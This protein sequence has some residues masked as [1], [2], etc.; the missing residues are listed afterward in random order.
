MSEASAVSEADARAMVRLLG[1]VAS[2]GREHSRMKR[3][4]MEGLSGLINADAWV[5]TLGCQTVLEKGQVLAGFM[6][7][8][9][10]E[11]R[12]ASFVAAV[13]NPQLAQVTATFYG[14]LLRD[15][16]QTTML[17]QEIDPDGL[18]YGGGMKEEWEEI[19]I[20][21]ILI[22]AYP[23]DQQ[24]YSAVAFYR[25]LKAPLFCDRDKQLLHIMM[26]EVPWLHMTGWPEDRG[27]QVP[28]LYPQQ[29]II[30][31]LLLDGSSRKEITRHMKLSEHT[32]SGY[33][34]DVFRHFGVN[35]QAS[36]M[37]K[38]MTK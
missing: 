20:G 1:D 13:E 16:K 10:D 29:R 9:F 7:G 2:H 15:Q 31:N 5:W 24:S 11:A 6:H 22:S 28:T 21:P 33:V 18:A 34:K 37:K 26:Q 12:F 35:S 17:R 23:L 4:L 32:V 8:G 25:R 14:K 38:F 36:L 3:V 30:L 27:A 19:D